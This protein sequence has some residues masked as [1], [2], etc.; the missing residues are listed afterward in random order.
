[1]AESTFHF[2]PLDTPANGRHSTQCL[3]ST[4]NTIRKYV[5]MIMTGPKVDQSTV[6]MRMKVRIY[7]FIL[8]FDIGEVLAKTGKTTLNSKT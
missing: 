8:S 3:G 4:A 5:F 7:C 2:L 1:M 6:D